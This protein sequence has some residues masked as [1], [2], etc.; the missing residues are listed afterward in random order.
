MRHPPQEMAGNQ[1]GPLQMEEGANF[2]SLGWGTERKIHCSQCH[3]QSLSV[4]TS[5]WNTVRW[6][7]SIVQHKV[8]A[9]SGIPICL[10][11]SLRS[12]MKS[13]GGQRWRSRIELKMRWAQL[14]VISQHVKCQHYL[15]PSKTKNP[16]LRRERWIRFGAYIAKGR[17]ARLS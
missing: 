3:G 10:S 16:R 4:T 8:I 14:S 5:L 9:K 1:M 12:S 13:S 11:V 2:P 17:L 6:A 15:L 7:N